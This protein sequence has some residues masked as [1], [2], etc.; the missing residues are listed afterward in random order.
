MS[1]VSRQVSSSVCSPLGDQLRARPAVWP[2]QQ[3][4]PLCL[5][6][7][8]WA[9]KGP[10]GR[11]YVATVHRECAESGSAPCCHA[12]SEFNAGATE[13]DCRL[14]SWPCRRRPA[15]PAAMPSPQPPN[16]E[17]RSLRGWGSAMRCCRS[18]GLADSRAPLLAALTDSSAQSPVS[19]RF[20]AAAWRAGMRVGRPWWG[21]RG[22]GGFAQCYAAL[23]RETHRRASVARRQ[24]VAPRQG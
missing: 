17:P 6:A 24:R 16:P 8:D 22:R 10:Q 1:Y 13:T 3:G 2:D 7:S 9:V 18:P 14:G 11:R 5:A 20:G 12:R 23:R 15:R 21:G 4:G 19:H